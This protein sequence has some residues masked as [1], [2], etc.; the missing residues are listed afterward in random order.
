[1]KATCIPSTVHTRGNQKTL[2]RGMRPDQQNPSPQCGY[3]QNQSSR[4]HA[5]RLALAYRVVNGKAMELP[6][7]F[8]HESKATVRRKVSPKGA[9]LP[10][11]LG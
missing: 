3:R 9:G 7:P 6:R 5:G 1:M 2:A 10:A 4:C 8:S 11:S